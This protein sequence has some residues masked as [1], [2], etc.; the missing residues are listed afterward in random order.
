MHV[1][2]DWAAVAPRQRGNAGMQKA[3]AVACGTAILLC[4]VCVVGVVTQ[5]GLRGLLAEQ[6]VAQGARESSGLV[7]GASML[8]SVGLVSSLKASSFLGAT[9]S[10]SQQGEK[11]GHWGGE[12]SENYGTPQWDNTGFNAHYH[13]RDG[14]SMDSESM[15][16]WYWRKG[17]R[18][19]DEYT[20]HMADGDPLFSPPDGWEPPIN[21]HDSA[22]L[23]EAASEGSS[24]PL[25]NRMDGL[26][27]NPYN[28]GSGGLSNSQQ[29]E[30]PGHWG[31][32]GSE[33]YGTPQ[34]DNTGFNAHY[35]PRDGASM[36]SE[37]MEPW[38]WRKGSRVND[39]YTGHMADGDPLF[40]P[41]DGWEPPINYHDSAYTGRDGIPTSMAPGGN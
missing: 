8:G 25:M 12:G 28:G 22:Y 3:R 11:P 9:L 27:T 4:C 21:F 6:A 17:P 7:S 16:P 19:N 2:R 37:S 20:G 30:K 36:D 15:E 13:P 31:G 10:G 23:P 1:D 18:V 34:W 41:P 5:P 40:S 32:E 33:N 24:T 35:H 29:G 39:E 38:Y 14:A 26:Q